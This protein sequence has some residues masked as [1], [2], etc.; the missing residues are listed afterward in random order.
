MHHVTWQELEV[1]ADRIAD[2]WRGKVADVYG[3]PTGGVPLALMV[4]Q[5]LDVPIVAEWHLGHATLVVDDLIDTGKTMEKYKG[6]SYID[7]AFRK[8]W[9]PVQYAPHART[10]NEWLW[11]PW[12]HDEGD[13]HD[14]V[15]RLLQFIGED[16]TRDGLRDTPKRVC[17][18]LKEMTAGYETN[19]AE[20]LS[21]SFDVAYDEMVVVRNVPFSSMCEHH[22]LPF[23]GVVTVGYIPSK[24]VVGLSKLAR[25][26]DAYAKRLQVQE[27][28]TVEIAEAMET[29]LKPTG[30][31][32]VVRA[33]HSC[34]CNR[35][36]KK[37]GEMVTSSLHGAMRKKETVRAEFLALAG[38]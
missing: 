28:M 1:E 11:F 36:I 5:R 21:V 13:P 20:L 16:P 9:S 32:V 19:I 7:A 25:L 23:T 38:Y 8:P 15:T 17:K 26:V 31:G 10:M 34:M 18:A 27:R 30:C 14:A 37:T 29:Y 12:E 33:N 3:I 6:S 2:K 35:G 4:A 22:M 24:S